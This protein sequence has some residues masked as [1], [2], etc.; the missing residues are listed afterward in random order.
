MLCSLHT[1]KTQYTT[2]LLFQ[3]KKV[4][5][6]V[7]MYVCVCNKKRIFFFSF[8]ILYTHHNKTKWHL[9]TVI[10]HLALFLVLRE[11]MPDTNTT[12]E[13]DTKPQIHIHSIQ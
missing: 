8:S 13:N 11:H 7:C 1:H 5:M 4:H 9:I 6:H 3:W 2:H 12:L 10:C